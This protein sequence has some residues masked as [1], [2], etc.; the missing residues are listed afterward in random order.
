MSN[1]MYVIYSP[2]MERYMFVK[3]GGGY[4]E[5]YTMLW[6]DDYS[7]ASHM[8]YVLL[9]NLLDMCRTVSDEGIL[10]KC[11]GDWCRTV[12]YGFNDLG[13]NRVIDNLTEL[14]VVPIHEFIGVD[15]TMAEVLFEEGRYW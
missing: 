6:I 13:I 3:V 9:E 4:D 14:V 7:N 10:P 11:D 15:F 8:D 1:P 12:A 5:Y 2:T